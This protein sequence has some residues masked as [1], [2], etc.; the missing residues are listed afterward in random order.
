MIGGRSLSYVPCPLCLF[1]RR[2][3]GSFTSRCGVLFF[4]SVL[5][6]LI[7]LER[8][9]IHRIGWRVVVHIGLDPLP[10]RMDGLAR[11]LEFTR[12]S[13]CR[14]ALGDTTEQEYQSGWPLATAFKGRA[15]EERIVAVALTT[16]IGV[17]VALRTKP[18]AAS[19]PARGADKACW[20]QMPLQ[21]NEA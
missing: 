1:A 16:A 17:V 20:V 7:H 19:A 13:R 4:P 5:V 21:P 10:Q 2:R 15:A 18:A 9:A 6:E 11:E 14:F 12:Q 3:G 8:L